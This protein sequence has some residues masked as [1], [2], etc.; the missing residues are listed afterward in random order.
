MKNLQLG[1][2]ALAI[3]TFTQCN[4]SDTDNSSDGI[5]THSE[6][7]SRVVKPNVNLSDSAF[8]K[9]FYEEIKK[10]QR[11]PDSLITKGFPFK[12]TPQNE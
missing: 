12:L 4:S 2:L 11:E 7:T 9:S 5:E 6:D 8:V 10:E 3:L 1:V